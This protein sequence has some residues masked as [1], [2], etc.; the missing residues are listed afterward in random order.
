MN[1]ALFSFLYVLTCFCFIA[2]FPIFIVI[3]LD[4]GGE[5]GGAIGF[6]L[7]FFLTCWGA[8]WYMS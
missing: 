5:I 3:G 8:C 7:V 1:A 4:Y 6:G 2:L